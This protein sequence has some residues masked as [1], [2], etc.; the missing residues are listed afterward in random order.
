MNV[1]KIAESNLLD[2]YEHQDNRWFTDVF[3]PENR[4]RIKGCIL[5]ALELFPPPAAVLDIGAHNGFATR[6]FAEV[7]YSATACDAID[8]VD[9]QNLLEEFDT[10]FVKSNLNDPDPLSEFDPESFDIVFMGEI[11]EHILNSPKRLL[12]NVSNILAEDGLLLLTTPNPS[13]LAN[14]VRLVKGSSF[15]RGVKSFTN[16][17]KFENCEVTADPTIHYREYTTDELTS[18]ISDVGLEVESV[19]YMPVG[20][21]ASQDILRRSVK[22]LASSLLRTRLLGRTQYIRARRKPR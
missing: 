6:I 9:R 17:T 13:T 2:F 7:G 1:Y 20:T 11:F 5:D 12:E 3:W 4:N 15:L 18:L 19:R 21:S 22:R 8:I 14:A 16:T 10:D